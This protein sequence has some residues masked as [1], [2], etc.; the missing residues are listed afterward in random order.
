MADND[1][2]EVFEE[3]MDDATVI[4]VPIDETLS[5]SGEAADAAAVG[6]ALALKADASSVVSISVNGEAADNQG[7]IIINGTH[8]K[9]NSSSNTTLTDAIEENAARNATNIPM[10]SDPGALSIAD[11]I[12]ESVD[13][14]ATEITMSAESETTIAQKIATMDT[15]ASANSSAISILN[16]KTAESIH[17]STQDTTPIKDVLDSCVKS[18]NGEHPDN[19]GNVAVLHALTADNLTSS[20]SQTSAG[21]FARRSTGGSASI[22]TGDAWMNVIRGSRTHVGYVPESLV[23]TLNTAPREEGQTPITATIDRDTFV[24]AVSGSTTINL[25]Y[26]ESWSASP[27]TYGVTVTGTPVSGDQITINYVA[28]DRGTII[29]SNPQKM[30]STGWNLY[31]HTNGYAIGLKYAENAQFRITG[32]YTAVKFSSTVDG[33]R[34]TITPVDGLFS[35]TANG[36]IWV[37]G[38]TS[39]DTEV[40]MTW[41]D[42]VQ[43]SD[44]PSTFEAYTESVIDLSELMED[45]FE[46]GLM[47][48]G[49]VRDEIDFNTGIATSKVERLAYSQ[50]NLDAAVAS[51]RTYEVDTNYIYLERAVPVE[52]D[53]D[54]YEDLDGQYAADDHGIEM[55]TGTSIAVYAVVVYGNNLK[56]K[57]ERNVLT[58][59]QQTLTSQQQGQVR[60]NI[61]AASESDL[62]E[63]SGK[64]TKDWGTVTNTWLAS[65]E[66][67]EGAAATAV[68]MGDRLVQFSFMTANRVH[69][70]DNVIAQIPSGYRPFK[71][72][73]LPS[74][75]A[76]G[77]CVL[78]FKEN[79]DVV[80][81]TGA[82]STNGRIYGTA[83][84][85]RA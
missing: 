51:G 26:T 34:T 52:F 16:G 57:L 85:I 67:G 41:N 55:F 53:L 9:M 45:H 49:D 80:I 58:I 66:Q 56:N 82:N 23:M 32:T 6:A 84:Y 46:Y 75:C 27:E 79:G 15:I 20:Q 61:G 78:R 13:R 1:L 4:T 36:Y 44:A 12:D 25:T 19:S 17:M 64:I 63:L 31:N 43:I 29:Q 28:E 74:F 65:A 7:H 76:G 40:Y 54:D 21:E 35:I 73:D 14:T 83:V 39:T 59:S 62:T 37:E 42:W 30:V 22:Q 70:N 8:I 77:L 68:Y 38:G 33:A 10:S 5:N 2:N 47:R 3:T 48:V 72:F 71:Q 18:V 69:A 81:W 50:E 11:A 24:E 60:T